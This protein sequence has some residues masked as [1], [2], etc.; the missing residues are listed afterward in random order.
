MEDLN[1][2]GAA[3]SKKESIDFP[4]FSAKKF[5]NPS[6]VKGPVHT[7]VNIPSSGID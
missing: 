3:A 1:I 4:I 2:K 6:E 5:D 7:I